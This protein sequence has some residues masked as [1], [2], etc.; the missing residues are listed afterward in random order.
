VPTYDYVCD[1][2]G[3]RFERFQTISEAVL[4]A[5]PECRKRRLRR[6]IGAGAG[7]LFKGSGFY[8]TDYKRAP[9]KPAGAG[10]KQDAG[11]S[12]GSGG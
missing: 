5:C 7:I 11:P 1:A 6:L 8:E 2:C 12:A 10:G 3:H 9:G 4:V